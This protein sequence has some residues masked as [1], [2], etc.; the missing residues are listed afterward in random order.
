MNINKDICMVTKSQFKILKEELE[1]GGRKSSIGLDREHNEMVSDI[2][3][4]YRTVV[5][6]LELLDLAILDD[7]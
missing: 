5:A 4:I 1:R 3:K 6:L 2:G 7:G